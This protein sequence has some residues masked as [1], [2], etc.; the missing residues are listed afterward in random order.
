MQ[1]IKDTWELLTEKHKINSVLSNKTFQEINKAYSQKNRH[2]HNL[3]HVADLLEQTHQHQHLLQDTDSIYFAIFFHDIVYKA[4]NSDNEEQSANFAKKMLEETAIEPSQIQKI[5]QYILATKKHLP[6]VADTDLQFLLD[7]DLS[8]L[9]SE[10]PR[11]QL[12]TQ[13][14]RKEYR[15]YPDLIYKSGRKK[16][17]LTFLDRAQIFHFY[18]EDKEKQA[19]ENI[20]NEIDSL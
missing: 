11:Y 8:I 3:A 4:L 17:M 7:A 18:Q 20:K 16:A 15:I 14:I 5:Y 1:I 13:Q 9:A 12:Y 6:S 2:Y 10:P 19:R